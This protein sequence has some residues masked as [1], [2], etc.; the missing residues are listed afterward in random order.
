MFISLKDDEV[1]P[2]LCCFTIFLSADAWIP[3]QGKCL[4]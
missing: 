1:S 4:A 2:C 3:F